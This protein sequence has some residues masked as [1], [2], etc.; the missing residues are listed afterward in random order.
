VGAPD[1]DPL[2]KFLPKAYAIVSYFLRIYHTMSF[3]LKY[4][5]IFLTLFS[6]AGVVDGWADGHV[7]T[8]ERTMR[9]DTTILDTKEAARLN[10][11]E[12]KRSY[13]RDEEKKEVVEYQQEEQAVR[14][15]SDRRTNTEFSN[16]PTA[17]I[18]SAK[19]FGAS[20]TDS[21]ATY[22][23]EAL[24]QESTFA[25]PVTFKTPS[26]LRPIEQK[27]QPDQRPPS[28]EN[29]APK[30]TSFV[31][32]LSDLTVDNSAKKQPQ[33]TTRTQNDKKLYSSQPDYNN[34]MPQAY[35]DQAE[36]K[37]SKKPVPALSDAPPTMPA[38]TGYRFYTITDPNQIE[39]INM[40][41]VVSVD[42]DPAT[43]AFMI[44]AKEDCK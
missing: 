18:V 29:S 21:P 36:S 34:D 1:P 32:N 26:P 3:N 43:G 16:G 31:P 22:T 25:S 38:E 2:E 10:F 33:K 37:S 14:D 24:P 20:I 11:P 42:Q 13:E 8:S 30:R 15:S 7:A 40:E 5:A 12:K 19:P 17:T 35:E 39:H 41:C 44:K 28:A 27:F 6:G 23:A 9:T 4:L